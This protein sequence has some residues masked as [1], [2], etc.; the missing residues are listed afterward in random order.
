MEAMSTPTCKRSVSIDSWHSRACGRPV[1]KDGLCGI[2]V[3]VVE[4][5]AVKR[6]AELDK[7]TRGKAAAAK[8]AAKIGMKV[9]YHGYNDEN[10]FVVD[11]EAVYALLDSNL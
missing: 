2:H 1:K 10:Y 3:A 6:Q 5:R 9:S 11:T 7:R 8:L 4:R